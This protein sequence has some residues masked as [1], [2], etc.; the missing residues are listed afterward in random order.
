MMLDG[1]SVIILGAEKAIYQ[2]GRAMSRRAWQFRVYPVR[3][4]GYFLLL[5]VLGSIPDEPFAEV[6]RPI[7]M[8]FYP[9]WA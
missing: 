9:S 8:G 1:G 7:Q 6:G 5:P 3:P 2:V 4:E